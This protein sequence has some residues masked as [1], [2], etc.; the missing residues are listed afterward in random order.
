MAVRRLGVIPIV[1]SQR[2]TTLI[3]C[4]TLDVARVMLCSDRWA[5]DRARTLHA[6][7]CTGSPTDA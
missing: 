3:I 6:R 2:I 5:E 4:T 1:S 7:S